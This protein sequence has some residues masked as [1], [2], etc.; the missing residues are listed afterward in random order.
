MITGPSG[1][2]SRR[3]V[4]APAR[5]GADERG[6]ELAF[7]LQRLADGRVALPVFSTVAELVRVLG[8]YQPWVC[9]PLGHGGRGNRPGRW[10]CGAGSRCGL[11]CVAVVLS[12]PGEV[13]PAYGWTGRRYT[14]SNGFQVVMSDL[15]KMSGTFQAESATFKAIIP[16]NG[17]A[18]PGGSS[19]EF[20]SPIMR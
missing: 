18:R 8:R 10:P 6:G 2:R 14:V 3:L 16:A 9:V 5:S 12:Q 1:E 15:Q 4:I 13:R 19:A 11:S 17:P 20:I 7:E